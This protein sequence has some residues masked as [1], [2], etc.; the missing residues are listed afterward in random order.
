MPDPARR[1]VRDEPIALV[2]GAGGARGLAQIG[3]IEAI[4][5]RGLRIATIA[6]S[7]SGALVGGFQ[8]AGRLPQLRDWLC[9]LTRTRMLR[10]VDPS[11]GAALV[12]GRRLMEQ[13]REL[14]GVV[15]I[16][17]LNVDLT[18]VAVDLMRQREVWLRRGDLLEAIRASIAIPGVF[19]PHRIAGRELVDGGV[20]APLPIT[21][22]RLSAAHRLVAVDMHGWPQQPPTQIPCRRAPRSPTT[23]PT[24]SARASAWSSWSRAPSTPCSRRSR[25]CSSRSIRPSWSSASRAMPASSTSSG[26]RG[27]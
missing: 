18:I 3:V 25:A 12:G 17:S 23:R 8:A 5:A 27:R 24:P 20:L 10:Y 6:G 13:L 14:L 2:L 11:F 21:A 22:T 15:A 9:S 7:S 19:A 26:G 1:P 16:E 4:E